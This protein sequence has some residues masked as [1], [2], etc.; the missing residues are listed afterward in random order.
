ML[1]GLF[2]MN[3]ICSLFWFLVSLKVLVL[4]IRVKLLVFGIGMFLFW[5]V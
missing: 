2:Y 3:G 1:F 4:L 5:L